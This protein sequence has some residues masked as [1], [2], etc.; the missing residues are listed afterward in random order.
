MKRII[1]SKKVFIWALCLSVIGLLSFKVG[2]KYF[3]IS[4]NLELY[5]SVFREIN[6]YYVDEIDAGKMN[7][8][9]ID[10]ML[11]TLDPYTNFISEAEAEDFRFQMTGQYGGVGAQIM[12]R[13]DYVMITDPYQVKSATDNIGTFDGTNPDIRFS[14]TMGATELAGQVRDKLNETFNHP[15]KLSWW[16][17]TVGSQYNLAERSPAY[18]RVFDAA[19]FIG[20]CQWLP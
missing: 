17:K 16:H 13:D 19:L 14:R 5:A 3:E 15:G 18:K 4:K 11:K 20:R 12:Q 6:T 10:E 1:S 9:A 7:K 2:D 8:K